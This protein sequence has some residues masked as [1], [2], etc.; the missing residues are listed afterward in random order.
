MYAQDSIELL[1]SSGIEFGKAAKDGIDID[2]FGSLLITSG[3]VLLDNVK[4]ISFHS[5][6]DLGYL[7]KTMICKPLP[8]EESDFA[9]YIR[10]FFPVLYD[11]KY[12]AKSGRLPI[13]RSSLQDIAEEMQVKRVGPQ[14]QAGSDSLLTGRLFFEIRKSLNNGSPVGTI[15]EELT[16]KIWGLNGV[17]SSNYNG[18]NTHGAVIYNQGRPETPATTNGVSGNEYING[19]GLAGTPGVSTPGPRDPAQNVFQYGKMGGGM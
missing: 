11:I 13:T 19:N 2:E 1:K 10:T 14:H 3:L 18:V 6:Y 8:F 16:G 17:G 15:D 12:L 4:W 5:G 7:V 9:A